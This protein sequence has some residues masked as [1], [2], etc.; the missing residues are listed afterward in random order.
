MKQRYVLYLL[1]GI[2]SSVG[3]GVKADPTDFLR[4][5]SRREDFSKGTEQSG[6][7]H[8]TYTDESGQKHRRFAPVE[9]IFGVRRQDDGRYEKN[10]DYYDDEDNN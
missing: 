5:E 9:S 6:L 7:L 4:P 2:L 10:D 3:L 8:Q 1:I